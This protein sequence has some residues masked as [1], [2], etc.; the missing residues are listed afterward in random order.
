MNRLR[1]MNMIS[2]RQFVPSEVC[3]KCGG[4]C[5]YKSE[6]SPWRPKLGARDQAG[7]GV[8]VTGEDV[9]DAQAYIKTI[10]TCGEHFC[11]FL[12][13]KDNSCG[14]YSQRPFEC[15]LYPFILS[16]TPET[17]KVYVHLACPYIQDHL[18][19]SEYDAYVVYLKDF[20]W[21]EDVRGFLAQNTNMFH[22][23]TSF[24]PELL[25]LFDLT[26]L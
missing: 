1:G 24:A 7:L 22:D 19:R 15:S 11:K 26:Y 5:R 2:L 23:Y 9:L 21:R 16:K 14:I 13:A 20:F 10:Q 4:C 8:L 6:D 12:N 17:V 25:H 18:S 3:L